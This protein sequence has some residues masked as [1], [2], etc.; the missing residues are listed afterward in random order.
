[1]CAQLPGPMTPPIHTHTHTHTHKTPLTMKDH[2]P[3]GRVSFSL[4]VGGG[5]RG[6]LSQGGLEPGLHDIPLDHKGVLRG[7]MELCAACEG[8]AAL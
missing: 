8:A 1:M 2:V 7:L 4:L 5:G 3:L 6:G